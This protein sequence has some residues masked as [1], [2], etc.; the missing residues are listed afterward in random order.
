MLPAEQH[1]SAIRSFLGERS[2]DETRLRLATEADAAF[3]LGLRLD[4]SRN[5]NISPTS[6]DLDQQLAWMRAYEARNAAG[7]EAYFL[8][9]V[10]GVPEGSIRLYDYLPQRDSFCWGSWI[11][12]P[13]APMATA[14]QSVMILYDLGFG[15]LGFARAH[16]DVRQENISVWKFH[17]K[18]GATMGREDTIDRFYEYPAEHYKIART[19]LKRLTQMRDFR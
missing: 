13:G 19:W 10:A 4:P 12:R 5:K 7:R 11:I 18:M 14:F 9:E 17:E 2:R 8:I 1:S 3:L 6:S 15:P 16:F